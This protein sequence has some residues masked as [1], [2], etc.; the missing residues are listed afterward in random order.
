MPITEIALLHLKPTVTIDDAPVRSSLRAAKLAMESFTGYPFHFYTQVDDPSYIYVVGSWATVAQ[1]AEE[2]IPSQKNQEI[3]ASVRDLLD[4]DWMFHVDID[5]FATGDSPAGVMPVLAPTLEIT[6]HFVQAGKAQVFLA[7]FEESRE[8]LAEFT[9]PQPVCGGWRIDRE[10][11]A[12]NN[13]MEKEEFLLFCGWRD[14]AHNLEFAQTE[15]FEK[16][17]ETREYLTAI[18]TKHVTRWDI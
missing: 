10:R 4:V 6:R 1:H 2:W 16:Y 7:K 17:K 15:A 8:S 13:G 5:Q 14:V 11:E 12:G 3:L 9:A 18:E